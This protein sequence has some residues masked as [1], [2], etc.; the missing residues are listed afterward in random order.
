MTTPPAL[1][2]E[3]VERHYAQAGASLNILRGADLELRAGQSA[4]LIAPVRSM[5][6]MT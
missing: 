5:P 6:S 1:H 3:K 4:A 2:L